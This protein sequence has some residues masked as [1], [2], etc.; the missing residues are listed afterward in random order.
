[1]SP[2]LVSQLNTL[3]SAGLIRL[4]EAQPDLEYLFRHA[5]VQDA[6][7]SSLLKQDRKQL[8]LTVGEALEN[9]YPDQC[10]EL[11]AT[12]AY[13]FEKA[14]VRDRAVR[15]LTLAGDRARDGYANTE[16]MDFY[17][18]AISQVEQILNQT[19]P[20]PEAWS[21]RLARLFENLADVLELTGQHEAARKAYDQALAAQAQ[22]GRTGSAEQARVYRK[23]GTTFTAS[24]QHAEAHQAWDQGEK[25]LGPAPSEN[26]QTEQANAWRQE[27][28]DI[29]VERAWNHYWQLQP[30]AIEKLYERIFPILEQFGT[31]TQRAKVMMIISL[32]R[33]QRDRYLPSD[34]TLAQAQEALTAALASGDFN[35]IFDTQFQVGF[36]HLWRRE[37]D[38]AEG[39]LRASMEIT[40]RTGDAVRKSRSVTYLMMLARM[41]G[42]VA[43]ARNYIPQ[44]LDM[45]WAGQMTN[46]TYTGKACLAW[47][48][49]REGDY[50]EV[51]GQARTGLE[52]LHGH[53]ANYPIKW[54][55]LL[56]LLAVAATGQNFSEAVEH[57]RALLHPTQARLP[58][59]LN[60]ALE[61]AIVAYEQNQ[62][63]EV[64]A[65]LH[66]AMSLA[67]EMGYL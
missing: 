2:D 36:L 61:A 3:E 66:R 47:A 53:L 21:E 1:M 9:L 62:A 42:Q 32:S 23:I 26:D 8:H 24:R 45:A 39:P 67:Q 40:E 50:A 35:L 60:A 12:L 31:P 63:E 27:W 52:L 30:E 19:T 41:R 56:P 64:R 18:L 48:A 51:R 34:E 22:L 55:A 7:Y 46:Y 57:A 14:E 38:Q 11:A 43:E 33:V 37:F 15:Y 16:A 58:E 54:L 20:P 28:V 65:Q 13:H 29:Q 4:A 10:D 6:A 17:M 25:V 59:T 5:L 44:V 49:W